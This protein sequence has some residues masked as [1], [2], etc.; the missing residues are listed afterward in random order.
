[1][2]FARSTVGRYQTS[3]V[4]ESVAAIDAPRYEDRGDGNGP[5][6]LI[7]RTHEN[8]VP[9]NRD[10]DAGTWLAPT[11]VV[12]S[13]QATSPD[14]TVSAERCTNDSG[15]RSSFDGPFTNGPGC[16]SLWVRA[17]SG[18]DSHQ[19]WVGNGSTS[20]RGKRT[21]VD[22]NWR[23]VDVTFISPLPG[24]SSVVPSEGRALASIP[25]DAPIAQASDLLVD[26]VQWCVSARYPLSLI[27]TA[28]T[29]ATMDED[30][31]VWDEGD[32]DTRIATETWTI[33]I[34][35]PLFSSGT[36]LADAAERVLLSFEADGGSTHRVYLEQQ[37]QGV[38]TCCRVV[39]ESD[40]GG[41]LSM[42]SELFQHSRHDNLVITVS[43]SEGWIEVN[44]IRGPIGD[45]MNWPTTGALRLGGTHGGADGFDG[46]FHASA[47]IVLGRVEQPAAVQVLP[48]GDSI[49]V[50]G[51]A[52]D[53]NGYTQYMTAELTALTG[54]RAQCCGPYR[55]GTVF[56]S[57]HCG[58]NGNE[59]AD[60]SARLSA[61]TGPY[62]GAPNLL[63]TLKIG[64]GSMDSGDIPGALDDFA[65]LLDEIHA[66]HPTANLLVYA[67]PER[68][69]YT[70]EVSTYNAALP[71]LIAASAWPA[72]Q[73]AFTNP[74]IT[75]AGLADGVHPTGASHQIIGEDFGAPAAAALLG[76]A[77]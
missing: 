24:T 4:T 38:V 34:C 60:V 30:A 76:I 73:V 41:G 63:V 44:G 13:D 74:G 50:G 42:Q 7:E 25:G 23:R 71:G 16:L 11:G 51:A 69:G 59:A 49:T 64:T 28:G 45:A 54:V 31:A 9:N 29:S 5:L 43:P 12:A 77:T 65:A 2:T 53:N 17:V 27:E 8:L 10:L 20:S 58:V 48:I 57:Q 1:M 22:E 70:A 75:T 56:D 67:I 55:N 62:V 37:N 39:A 66:L 26:M 15:E 3:A 18:T 14:G 47:P 36:D 52:V 21:P 19:M 6:F 68:T 35:R 32:W 46:R 72:S 33:P 40:D 61:D